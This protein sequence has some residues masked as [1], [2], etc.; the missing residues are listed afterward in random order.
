MPDCVWQAAVVFA[1][2]SIC[3]CHSGLLVYDSTLTNTLNVSESSWKTFTGEQ[4][5]N[6]S[7]WHLKPSSLTIRASVLLSKYANAQ[8]V[9]FIYMCRLSFAPYVVCACVC[10]GLLDRLT[11]RWVVAW[12]LSCEGWQMEMV[13]SGALR[14][15]ALPLKQPI[16][17]TRKHLA[18]WISTRDIW[19]NISTHAHMLF[20]TASFIRQNPF[21]C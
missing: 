20:V 6:V 16:T 18:V 3:C 5:S 1:T 14:T 9:A 17:D 15:L 10:Y 2:S 4:L 12:G 21:S 13:L 7:F 19:C 8:A 11:Q